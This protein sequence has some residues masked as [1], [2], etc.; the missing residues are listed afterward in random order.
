MANLDFLNND[1]ADIN[2]KIDTSL[3]FEKVQFNLLDQTTQWLKHHQ[4]MNNQ[5]GAVVCTAG[6]FEM[7]SLVKDISSV[8]NMWNIN[9]KSAFSSAFIASKLLRDPGLL[10]LTGAKA[11][12]DGGTTFAVG[13]GM[14][15]AATH[16]LAL[17]FDADKCSDDNNGLRRVRCILPKT[18]DTPA[19]RQAMPSA[20][21]GQ[22]TSPLSI[23][24]KI[25]EW[26][27]NPAKLSRHDIFVEV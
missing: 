14:A 11:V 4:G 7:G 12:F 26:S 13:Y 23:A 2:L 19:N 6:G 18:I 27:D 20:D 8:E 3:D 21:F 17:S 15:K 5:L 16:H 10:V 24:E 22:W 9:A 25:S 1:N